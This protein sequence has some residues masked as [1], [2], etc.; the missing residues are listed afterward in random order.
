MN[1]YNKIF[2]R[3]DKFQQ[4]HMILS[5][6][7]AIFKKYGDDEAGNQAALITYFGF[8]SLFPLLLVFFS[9]LKKVTF[10]N[11]E[12]ENRIIG[13]VLHYFPGASQ[14]IVQNIHGY[15]K[16]GLSLIFG[17]IIAIYGARGITSAFQNASNKLWQIPKEDRPDFWHSTARSFGIIFLG[18]GGIIITTLIL[19][20]TNNI[21]HKGIFIKFIVTLFTLL[22]N[23]LVF[24]LIFR[25]A[26]VKSVKTRWLMNGAIVAAIFWQ[27]LQFIGSYLILNHLR[28]T[29]EFYG[30]FAVVLGMLFWIYLQAEVTIYAIELNV[31]RTKK[32]WPQKLVN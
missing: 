31:V 12:L 10:N 9:I 20:F 29:S 25:L 11:K 3:F 27:I 1:L 19:S 16:N 22:L 18:G 32:L 24:T 13:G 7:I 28:T 21:F 6:P 30:I 4:S 8:V 14:Q 5:F 26:T 15:Q 17:L 2:F 23:I